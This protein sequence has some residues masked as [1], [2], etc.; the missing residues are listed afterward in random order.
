MCISA[1][2][3]LVSD[4]LEGYS[5]PGTIKDRATLS[6]NLNPIVLSDIPTNHSSISIILHIQGRV[7]RDSQGPS[8]RLL[9]EEKELASVGIREQ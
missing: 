6:C 7:D 5:F 1:I 9:V 8:A 4:S 3:L 2:A